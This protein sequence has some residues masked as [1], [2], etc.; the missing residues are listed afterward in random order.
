MHSEDNIV[1]N[2][3]GAALDPYD[4]ESLRLNPSLSGGVPT[5]K[6]IVSIK[7]DKPNKQDFIRVHPTHRLETALIEVKRDKEFY[8]VHPSLQVA[9]S[10][11]CFPVVVL[12]YVNTAGTPGWWPIRLPTSDGK[13]NPYHESALALSEGAKH[14]WSRIQANLDAGRYEATVAIAKMPEPVWP[15]LSLKKL[16]ELAF[17]GR[18]IDDINHPV[19]QKLRGEVA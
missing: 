16:I 17:R 1:L 14:E 8:L 19:L 3:G 6:V 15:D 18:I 10:D 11:E 9:V 7:V 5:K 12:F 4:P 13:H 2:G